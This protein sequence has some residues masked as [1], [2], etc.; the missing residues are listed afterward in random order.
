MTCEQIFTIQKWKVSSELLTDP[1][2]KGESTL[3]R[4]RKARIG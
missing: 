4:S 1:N 3:H 2:L